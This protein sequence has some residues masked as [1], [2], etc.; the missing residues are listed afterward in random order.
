MAR[1]RNKLDPM[2]HVLLMV[3]A[4]AVMVLAYVLSFEVDIVVHGEMCLKP[5][6]SGDSLV[7]ERVDCES[8]DP[9]RRVYPDVWENIDLFGG[10]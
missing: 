2:F 4:V 10:K 7:W 8:G 9:L 1:N 5:L 6:R 3:L